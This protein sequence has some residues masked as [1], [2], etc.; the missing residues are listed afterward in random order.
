[1]SIP[2]L[3]AD[4]EPDARQGHQ[5]G[6]QLRNAGLTWAQVAREIGCT[7]GDAAYQQRTDASSP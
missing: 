1:M 6:W 5:D 2:D 4:D 7:E 3:R